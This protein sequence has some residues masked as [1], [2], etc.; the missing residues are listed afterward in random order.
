MADREDIPD[1]Y[2]CPYDPKRS[3]VCPHDWGGSG[4]F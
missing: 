4:K 1:V 2:L 3:V